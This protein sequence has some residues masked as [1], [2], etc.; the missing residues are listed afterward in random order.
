MDLIDKL[1]LLLPSL[2]EGIAADGRLFKGDPGQVGLEAI[3][4]G[5]NLHIEDIMVV[6][7]VILVLIS[8][9]SLFDWLRRQR[10]RPHT[11]VVFNRVAREAGLNRADRLLLWR[12]GRRQAL[13]TPLTLMLCPG[14][15]GHHARADARNR[16]HRRGTLDLA[17]AASIRRH[18]F[19]QS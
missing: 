1:Q 7:G 16:S 19:G 2:A 17:R 13:P 10:L 5:S 14:T 6:L 15:L 9:V 11:L 3:K 8:L 4:N 12:I 18:L